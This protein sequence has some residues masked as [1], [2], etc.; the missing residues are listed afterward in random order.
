[1]T[2]YLLAVHGSPSDPTPDEA[3][4]QQAYA[5]VDAFNRRLQA[6]GAWVFAGGLHPVEGAK[7][8][9]A[10]QGAAADAT[11]TDGPFSEAEEV[12]GGFWVV[13]AD[14]LDAALDLAR[15]GSQACGQPVE[16]R[17]FAGE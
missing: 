10:G 12:L 1:M 9:D 5:A 8:V 7:V 14:S 2:G 16:I 6:S 13:T 3:Q 4:I 17:E 15:Q 11:V